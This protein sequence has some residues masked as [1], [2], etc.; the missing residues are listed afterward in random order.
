MKKRLNSLVLNNPELD[1]YVS[2]NFNSL[3]LKILFLPLLLL[4][5]IVLFL[6]TKDAFSVEAYAYVQKDLFLYL[7]SKLSQ[8]PSLQYNLTQLGDVL[9]LLPF[10]TLFMVQAPKF[11]QSLITS[12]IVS[13]VF[14]NLF[15]K[16]FAVP[17]PAA[18]FDQDSF[19]IIG[20]TLTGSNSLPSGHSI[21]TFT[22]V[23]SVF[24]AF[25]PKK[26]KLKIAW[27][28]FIFSTGLFIALT[29]VGVGA[30]Y[31]LDIVVGSILGYLAAIVG[32]FITKKFNPWT[33][34]TNKK[35]YPISIVLFSVWAIALINKIVAMNLLVFYFSLVSLVATLV[36]ITRIYVKK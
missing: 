16:I 35:Y 8:F 12:L 2:N 13:A 4:L 25:M 14:S 36:I 9:I 21:A 6:F 31:P 33:W 7:N 26:T 28:L 24:F 23:A 34:L 15:K 3:R 17:R 18:M 20:R 10:L 19:V 29:R 22:I 32:I 5:L 27:F 30:H 1:A 11:W